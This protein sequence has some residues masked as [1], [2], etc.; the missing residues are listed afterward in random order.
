MRQSVK[1]SST[2][3]PGFEDIYCPLVAIIGKLLCCGLGSCWCSQ[4][5]Y[6]IN[7]VLTSWVMLS[8]GLQCELPLLC[9]AERT[10]VLES[11]LA[12]ILDL[13]LLTE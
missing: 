9:V 13:Q 10:Q 4:H 3:S 5:L 1:H 7:F 2:P 8:Q 11:D 12:E 6:S